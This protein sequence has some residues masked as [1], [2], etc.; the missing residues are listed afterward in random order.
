M[1]SKKYSAHKDDSLR[2]GQDMQKNT[3]LFCSVQFSRSVVSNSLQPHESQHARPP[4]PLAAPH[5]YEIKIQCIEMT[6]SKIKEGN[7][8]GNP[9]FRKKYKDSFNRVDR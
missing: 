3:M 4:C 5:I 9:G 6:N 7:G 8:R 2:E 1:L